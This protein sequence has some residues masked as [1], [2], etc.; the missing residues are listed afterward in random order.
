MALSGPKS[1][2]SKDL[3]FHAL[4]S[5]T[6]FKVSTRVLQDEALATSNANYYHFKR[7]GN[8]GEQSQCTTSVLDLQTG[9]AFFAA[10][11][12]NGVACWDSKKP[13]EQSNFRE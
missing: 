5:A 1:D 3:Y 7:L 4:A 2:G 9:V 8:K 12:R 6:E 10:I 13:L 11:S